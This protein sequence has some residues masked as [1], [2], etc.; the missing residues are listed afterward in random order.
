[1]IT[2]LTGPRTSMLQRLIMTTDNSK[3]YRL[4][5]PPESARMLDLLAALA[6]VSRSELVRTLI[7]AAFV[8]AFGGQPSDSVVGALVASA[9]ERTTESEVL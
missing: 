8:R 6:G 9:T 5:L 3:F 1:M 7:D 4:S 2:E